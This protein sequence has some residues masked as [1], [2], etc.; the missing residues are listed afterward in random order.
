[1]GLDLRDVF[2]GAMSW[3]R[4]RVILDHLPAESAYR[5]AV[6]NALDGTEN[7]APPEPGVFGP[8]SQTDLLLARVGDLLDA[9]LWQNAGDANAPRPK[10]YPRPG[11]ESKVSAVSEEAIEYLEYLREH[12]GEAPPD[13]WFPSIR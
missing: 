11:M 10:P 9:Q 2:T 7:L 13:D 3:R 1:M 4:L 12:H 5:T 6:W 8:W